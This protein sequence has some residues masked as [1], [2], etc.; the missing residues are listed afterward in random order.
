M[1]EASIQ[2]LRVVEAAVAAAEASLCS[3]GESR[4]RSAGSLDEQLARSRVRTEP[5]GSDR[6]DRRYWW[7]DGASRV[8]DAGAATWALRLGP[9]IKA[10]R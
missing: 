3:A 10:F 7:F 5:L 4:Q 8:P 9:V 2:A 6:H 1:R